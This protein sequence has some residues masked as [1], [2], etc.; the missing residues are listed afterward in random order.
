MFDTR[1]FQ[2]EDRE[3]VLAIL[4]QDRPPHR[5]A[6]ITGW[7]RMEALRKSEL[8]DLRLCVGAPAFAYLNVWDRGTD[9]MDKMEDVCGF[10]VE[11]SQEYRGQGIG[12]RLYE[13]AVDFARK[14]GA[15]RLV[16]SFW[17]WT[18]QEPAIAF[19]QKRGFAEMERETPAFL[20]LTTWKPGP[21]AASLAQA[22]ADG[23]QIVSYADLGDTEAH[24][25]IFYDLQKT[26]IYA[27]PRRDTQPFTFEPFDDWVNFV[28][29]H[30]SWQ[31]DLCLIALKDG[32]WIGQSQIV[33]KTET[34]EVGLQCLTGVLDDH[35]GRGLATAL[36]VRATER[37]KAAGMT[38]I[39]TENHEDNAPMLAINRKFGFQPEPAIVVYNKVLREA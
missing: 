12:S 23:V 6:T 16:T 38:I 5:R 22:E 30:P 19:L 21:F 8:V 11:V 1:P 20:D 9:S 18:P 28:L 32:T 34:P 24:R 37:A 17:E 39:N 3:A 26:L 36:K 14:R 13:I 4:N 15:K 10:E 31:P 2:P 7:D 35:R 29:G 33:P 25:Q 27:V